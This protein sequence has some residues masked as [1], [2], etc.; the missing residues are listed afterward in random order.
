MLYDV[1]LV[2]IVN[3][4]FLQLVLQFLDTEPARWKRCLTSMY[5]CVR[6][7]TGNSGLYPFFFFYVV[8]QTIDS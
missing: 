1:I 4:C 5:V 2:V 3:L 8:S 6:E 7:K